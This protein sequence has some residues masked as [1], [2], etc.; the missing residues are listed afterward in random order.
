LKIVA[1]ATGLTVA[2]IRVNLSLVDAT[3][4]AAD[5][6]NTVRVNASYTP[7][8]LAAQLTSTLK[9]SASAELRAV[10]AEALAA[11]SPLLR[12]YALAQSYDAAALQNHAALTAAN[13]SDEPLEKTWICTLDGRTR[14]SH[15]RAD[16][17]RVPIDGKFPVGRAQMDFPGDRSAPPEEWKNC[18]VGSTQVAWPGQDVLQA[19]LRR[20]RGTFV[21]LVTADGRKLTITANHKVL[22]PAGYVTADSLRPGDEVIGS[23]SSDVPQVGD[24]PPRI[25][26]VYRALSEVRE[27]QRVVAGA[28]DFHGDITEGDVVEVVGTDRDLGGEVDERSDVLQ[29][30]TGTQSARSGL[31][32]AVVGDLGLGVG[33]HLKRL[34]LASASGMSGLR[35]GE[36]FVGAHLGH[37][38]EIG[39]GPSA[40]VEPS[41][42][43][44]ANGGGAADSEDARHLF[45]A[46]A[47]G[48]KPVELSAVKIYSAS[49]DVYNLSTTQE[50]F[51]G[52]GIA[53]HNCRCRVG[54]LAPDEDIPDELD[55]HTE[56]LDGR[57]SVVVNRDGRTQ[58]EEIRR[59]AAQGETRAR[60]ERGRTAS[61][62]PAL[63][64]GVMDT[65][66][67]F[68]DSVIG[69]VGQPTS[70]GRMLA[71]GIDLTFRAFPLPLMWC[72]QSKEGHSD[73]F[74]VGVIESA[75][76]EGDRVLASGYML[77]SVEADEAAAQLAHGVTSPSVD[78]AAAEWT[79]TDE[80]GVVVDEQD[81]WDR[82]DAGLP[83]LTTFTAAELIGTTLV[84]T[85]AFGDTSVSLNPERESRDV[86]LVAGAA[87]DFRPPTYDHRLFDNPN[88]SGP[89]LPTM[90]EDGRIYGHLAVFGQC[91][92]SIQTECVLVP[93]SPSGYGHFHTSPALRLD[94]GSRLPVGRLTVGTGHADPRLG[95]SPAA[96]HYDNTGSCFGLVRVGEDEHGVWFSGVAAPWATAD[97]IAQG[98]AS[99]LSGDWRDFGQGL[100]LVA[101]LAVNTPGFAARG[102]DD[103]QGRPIALVASM[104]PSRGNLRRTGMSV[105]DVKAAVRAVL[106][107]Q[108]AADAAA[109]VSAAEAVRRDE[110]LSRARDA[111]GEPLAP[112]QRIAQMLGRR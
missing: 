10:A 24:V 105:E 47:A 64:G 80:N 55:R 97:Q 73:S 62:E 48:M 100:D 36:P 93:R 106:S 72:R 39:L 38:A 33:S 32:A 83:V 35:V 63:A 56:R 68:T 37:S 95:A 17:L 110:V 104:G 85:A 3:P 65:F 14:P 16:G 41:F 91:H 29:W 19:T 109:R 1:A 26:E 7:A 112:A 53:V 76:V 52:N 75:R 101:A 18:V 66:R 30:A 67:T 5:L 20:H 69:L 57:D 88:L 8:T 86:A 82:V 28:M 61:G 13:N 40:D 108:A 99:P 71:A 103:D 54:V 59:R 2:E 96:A 31:G 49:H 84:A 77:N 81:L 27:P 45:H 74:T 79:Y 43:E 51:I 4:P 107:E 94:D 12:D 60:D 6:A 50:W 42:F 34:A 15:Y 21:D 11:D 102:R 70:D 23:S 87:D 90:G 25:E 9:N 92:R 89:T 46:H 98:I 58:E 44:V 78:L 22:T 111:V